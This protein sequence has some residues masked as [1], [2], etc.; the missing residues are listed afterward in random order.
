MR[1]QRSYFEEIELEDVLDD[2]EDEAETPVYKNENK[3]SLKQIIIF[4]VVM[5]LVAYLFFK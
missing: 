4:T 2:Y 1:L 3:S 5:A